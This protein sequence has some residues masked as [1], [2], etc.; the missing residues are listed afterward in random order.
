MT[1]AELITRWERIAAHPAALG[2]DAWLND[3]DR[4]ARAPYRERLRAADA[5][6]KAATRPVRTCL[7]GEANAQRHGWTRRRNWWYYRIPAAGIPDE[8]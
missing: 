2:D 6:F 1:A 4:S 5:S 3:L 7:W 8:V